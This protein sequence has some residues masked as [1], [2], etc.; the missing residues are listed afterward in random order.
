MSRLSQGLTACLLAGLVSAAQASPPAPRQE[1][2][3]DTPHDEFAS[4]EAN[5]ITHR[6]DN[7]WTF[8]IVPRHRAPVV[9]FHTYIDVGAIFED[10]GATGMAHMFEHMAF[11]G[12]DRIG[13]T[14][15]PAEKA[16]LDDLEEAYLAYQAAEDKDDAE[17]SRAA[18]ARFHDLQRRAG[19]LVDG[20]A[21]SKLLEEAGGSGSL[22]ASTSG[23]E[24]RYVVSLPSNRIELWAWLER[25][26]FRHPVLREF[27]KER[28]AVLEE[29]R[30]RV[31]SS[32]FGALL[33]ALYGTAFTKHPYRRPVIGYA[34]D[35]QRYTR[36]EAEA[37]YAKNYGV[38][39]F[40]TAIVGDVDP[41]TLIPLLERY[42][43]DLPPG[44]EPTRVDVVEPPQ[45]KQRRVEVTFPAMPM[46]MAAW[47]I[48]AVS[49]PDFA[50]V[51]LGMYVL[52]QSDT[53]RLQRAL[54]RESGQAAE[55][56][57]IAGLPGNRHPGLAL[58]YAIPGQGTTTSELE[59]AI[60][61]ELDR[62]KAE[63]PTAA[64][65]DAARTNARAGLIRQVASN[66]EFAGDLCEWQS[67]TGDWRNLFTR[68]EAYETI[69]AADIKAAM[70][71]YFT[72]ENRTVATL[73][74]PAEPETDE[75]K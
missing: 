38:Q 19:E 62:L 56:G 11:K 30:M 51:E 45:E 16:L 31:E 14:D 6:L 42:F 54:V 25:E 28:D 37:F 15:W 40:V 1:R 26:R 18:L 4:I 43:G 69:T 70:Q 58:I 55:V 36:T 72:K 59:A 20:E 8:L 12:S 2:P 21:F 10:D 50:A 39:R 73:V 23:E 71:R 75:A 61:G 48:P 57:G 65:L 44:P 7:G 13:T 52:C 68:T 17:A 29:R 49:S 5:V 41:E 46:L 74:P 35:L 34:A 67:K 27:Y 32:P 9:S 3:S 53:S 33:E 60:Y 64:E 63:G 24:T 22:N 66:E 47:H